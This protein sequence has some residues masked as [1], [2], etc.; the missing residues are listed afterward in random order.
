M[1]RVESERLNDR[2]PGRRTR[3][4]SLLRTPVPKL[5]ELRSGV[6]VGVAAVP[7]RVAAPGGT[8]GA[9]D[10][11]LLGRAAGVS[12][13]PGLHG[14]AVAPRPVEPAERPGRGAAWRRDARR[15]GDGGTRLSRDESNKGGVTWR[16]GGRTD[17]YKGDSI[18]SLLDT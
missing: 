5:L 10:G 11:H 15:P 18:L 3:A 2:E 6:R 4:A 14:D 16:G 9:G 1:A 13:P 8:S 17:D 12:P 7:S